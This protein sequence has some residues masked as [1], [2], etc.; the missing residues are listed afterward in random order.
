MG[1]VVALLRALE[2]LLALQEQ[3]LVLLE[4]VRRLQVLRRLVLVRRLQVQVLPVLALR[5]RL[6]PVRW[7]GACQGRPLLRHWLQQL[8]PVFLRGRL[9]PGRLLLQSERQERPRVRCLLLAL[10]PACGLPVIS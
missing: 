9:P 3:P 6:E 10:L 4:P 1:L 7:P 5:R 2:P 8:L